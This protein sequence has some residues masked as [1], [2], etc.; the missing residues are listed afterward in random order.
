MPKA[1]GCHREDGFPKRKE[2][3]FAQ[4]YSTVTKNNL[5]L[6]GAQN[7]FVSFFLPQFTLLVR[8]SN[9]ASP[10]ESGHLHLHNPKVYALDGVQR[11]TFVSTVCGR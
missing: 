3:V 7:Q 4:S 10:W 2:V 9:V 5:I 1:R 11:S 6:V 8:K